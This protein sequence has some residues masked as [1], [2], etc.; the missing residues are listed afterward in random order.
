MYTV[1]DLLALDPNAVA[2]DPKDPPVLPRWVELGVVSVCV[3][4]GLALVFG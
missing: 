3:A 2:F 4:I 1:Y